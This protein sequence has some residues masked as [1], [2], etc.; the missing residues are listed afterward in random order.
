[1]RF[2][3]R[4]LL[5]FFFPGAAFSLYNSNPSMPMMPEQGLFI[6]KESFFG[7]KAGYELD[8]IYQCDLKLDLHHFPKK[9]THSYRSLTQFGVVTVNFN[10]RVELFADM[11]ALS[12][13]WHHD[14]S[15][16]NQ[17]FYKSDFSW[18][19]GIGGR[20]ILAY[21]GE[22][23]LGV[24]ASYAQSHP[25]LS[26]LKV[27]GE[28]YSHDGA[29]VDLNPW[30]VGAGL[31]YR[32]GWFVPYVGLDYLNLTI[33]V[34]HLNSLKEV[35]PKKKTEFKN[36]QPMGF[37]LGMGIGPEIGFNVN[38]ELRFINEYGCSASADFKF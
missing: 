29:R 12:C 15:S 9:Q 23:Q 34:D 37:F 2:F 21:W 13:Q 17:I 1:M 4:I 27:N 32:F 7:L 26:Q 18:M 16:S 10:D 38:I 30:Q 20:A 35:L 6:S 24:N 22:L 3:Y 11:G 14:L 28:S 5:V 31:S 25:S 8:W 36:D 33:E 19:W